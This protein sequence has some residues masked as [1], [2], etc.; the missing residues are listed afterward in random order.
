MTFLIREKEFGNNGRTY[1]G[2]QCLKNTHAFVVI[3][4]MSMQGLACDVTHVVAMQPT[5]WLPGNEQE[6]PGVSLV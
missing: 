1:T 3:G 2:R 4:K 5:A 6:V